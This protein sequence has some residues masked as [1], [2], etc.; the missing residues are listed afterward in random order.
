MYSVTKT[1]IIIVMHDATFSDHTTVIMWN[2]MNSG[3][4]NGLYGI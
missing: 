2:F 3:T 4:E 1:A